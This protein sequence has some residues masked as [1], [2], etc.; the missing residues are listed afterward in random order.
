MTCPKT[1]GED[2][3]RKI[4]LQRSF[5]TEWME[6][7]SAALKEGFFLCFSTVEKKKKRT[8][9]NWSDFFFWVQKRKKKRR[10]KKKI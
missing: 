10:R 7:E 6:P 3:R 4:N 5:L 2:K 8:K 1:F 9:K